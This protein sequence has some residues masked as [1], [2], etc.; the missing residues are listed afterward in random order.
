MKK[1]ELFSI[2]YS[3][4]K[5]HKRTYIIGISMVLLVDIM[6]VLSTRIIGWILDFFTMEKLPS[7]FGEGQGFV[8]LFL[9][10]I[11]SRT[12]LALGRFGWRITLARQTHVAGN[13]LRRKIWDHA[14]YFFFTDLHKRF[15]KGMLLN[16]S[17]SD[18]ASA[19]SIFGFTIVGVVDVVFLGIFTLI[20]MATIHL[21]M[22]CWFLIAT[23][24]LPWIIRRIN[25]LEII[26]YRQSQDSLS[27]FDELASQTVSTIRMQKLTETGGVWQKRLSSMAQIYRQK[28]IKAVFTTLYYSIA[29]DGTN[30]LSYF[31]LFILG[32]PYVIEGQ[33]SIGD[34]VAMRGLIF[35][36][37]D[38]L[39]ELGW[40]ISDWQKATT[41]LERLKKVFDN[42][43][44]RSLTRK[45]LSIK[46]S[47]T[48]FEVKNLVFQYEKNNRKIIDRLS[49]D[50]H[51]GEYLAVTGPTGS[52]KSTLVSIMAGFRGD[53]MGRVSLY[54]KNIGLYSHMALRSHL[55]VVPQHPYLFADSIRNN[56]ALNRNLSDEQIL[57][58]LRFTQ[59]EEEVLGLRHGLLTQ[60]G[61][62]GIN[63]SGGQKQ[64]LA[65]ARALVGKPSVLFLDACLSAV[66]IP[67]EE[68]IVE[69]VHQELKGITL[70]WIS[71]RKTTLRYCNRFLEL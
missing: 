50:L 47:K 56:I 20:A 53:F 52:G 5:E 68:K 49:F 33:M 63:L 31:V 21:E 29:F 71:H 69:R 17:N 58:A 32:I 46:Q 18:V 23:F 12:I 13:F 70:V 51:Q 28:K 62:W 54:K 36:L 16:N 3:Y 43:Q 40:V 14:L 57:H 1:K 8:F 65:L 44:D 4:V 9:L 60:L 67:T 41:S 64:R 7:W 59:I 61:E 30:M 25:D 22:T 66:D 24:F 27:D 2:W 42:K 10:F 39:A 6:Q 38:P 45:G 15:S 35:L 19:R 11:S 55:G 48:V 34:F 26:R 37:K